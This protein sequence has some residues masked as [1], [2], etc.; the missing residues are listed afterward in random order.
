MASVW[1]KCT[2]IHLWWVSK[3]GTTYM[4]RGGMKGAISEL[5]IKNLNAHILSSSNN[6]SRI[7]LI[8]IFTYVHR[9]ICIKNIHCCTVKE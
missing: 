8:V 5:S 1:G 6:V 3:C 4:G 9:E 2:L 7:Y